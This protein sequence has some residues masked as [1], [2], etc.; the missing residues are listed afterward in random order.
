M[1]IKGTK[2]TIFI[3]GVL[4]M[5]ILGV[6]TIFII[7]QTYSVDQTIN[8]NHVN[9]GNKTSESLPF[10]TGETFHIKYITST[11][12]YTYCADY[13]HKSPDGINYNLDYEILDSG[14]VYIMS[15][16]ANTDNGSN[17][18]DYYV[19]Q[20]AYWIYD[21]EIKESNG[22]A[23]PTGYD[24]S[25]HYL[26]EQIN[27]AVSNGNSTAI[28]IRNLV[29]T[30]KS[31]PPE[32][33]TLT[34]SVN[35]DNLSFSLSDN[36]E[37]YVSNDV[38]VNASDGY[39]VNISGPK[40]TIKEDVAGGFRIKVPTSN[41]TELN[42]IIN[43]S[44]SSSKQITRA[45]LY[46]TDV[47][48]STGRDYQAVVLPVNDVKTKSIDL[49]GTIKKSSVTI[50][51]ADAT[52]GQEIPGA[53]LKLD[54]NNGSYIKQWESTATPVIITDIPEGTCTLSETIAP[55]GYVKTDETIKFTVEAGKVTAKQIMK[56][57]PQ[58]GTVVISKADA[59]TGEEVPGAELILKDK[60][61]KIIDEWKSTT[62]PHIIKGLNPGKYYLTETL[63]PDGYEL[64]KETVEFT[65]KKDGTVDKKVVML[66]NKIED[67]PKTGSLPLIIGW[68]IAIGAIG[69]SVYYFAEKKDK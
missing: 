38:M 24:S 62:D 3:I 22:T 61:G 69:Y 23:D 26:R 32:G 1:I 15:Q 17:Y 56:N 4:L 12:T 33:V 55:E 29:D 57:E 59:T 45:Y 21:Y 30:A 43:A 63:A 37:Y 68:V 58:K 7:K 25:V 35:S 19:G 44:I 48:S 40:G 39:N 11:N 5:I 46:T 42:T 36:G 27:N 8:F 60:N 14:R 47:T 10:S 66:N 64:N 65:V 34:L 31:Q 18:I 52:T 53:H 20:V 28:R 50:S 54:C 41:I 13:P 9:W 2:K 6:I 16:A 51:K 49:S 67:N